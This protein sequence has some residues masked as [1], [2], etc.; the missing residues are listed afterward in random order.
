[1]PTRQR[2]EHDTFHEGEKEIFGRHRHRVKEHPR[3]FRG[4]YSLFM[5]LDP[6]GAREVRFNPRQVEREPTMLRCMYSLYR[7]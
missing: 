2:K 7:L 4:Q 5:G 6:K 3:S 1:M